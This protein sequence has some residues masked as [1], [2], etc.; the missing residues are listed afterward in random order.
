MSND[1]SWGTA[2]R[3]LYNELEDIGRCHDEIYDSDVRE[4]LHVVLTHL[5]V[6]ENMPSSYP[7]AFEMFTP[8]GDALLISAQ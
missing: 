3:D 7:V 8:E 2:V 6:W 4:S 5:F 1:D